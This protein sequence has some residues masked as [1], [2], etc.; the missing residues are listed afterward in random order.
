MLLYDA[1]PLPVRQDTPF[2][3]P[4]RKAVLLGMGIS[5]GEIVSFDGFSAA[6][7]VCRIIHHI[8][9]CSARSD[10]CLVRRASQENCSLSLVPE[11]IGRS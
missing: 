2:P 11:S 4:Y 3:L 6:R 7:F 1:L 10:A 9:R 8:Q 5:H